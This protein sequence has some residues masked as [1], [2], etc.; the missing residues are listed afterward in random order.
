MSSLEDFIDLR[1]ELYTDNLIDDMYERYEAKDAI[2]SEPDFDDMIE[3]MSRASE[4]R[5]E[6]ERE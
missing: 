1:Y 4:E 3:E 6:M 2:I 5:Y